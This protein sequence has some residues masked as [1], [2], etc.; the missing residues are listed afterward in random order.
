MSARQ[1]AHPED[2]MNTRPMSS[3]ELAY[4][5]RAWADGDAARSAA[6][7]LLIRHGVWLTRADFILA[8]VSVV[9][10]APESEPFATIDWE[11]AYATASRLPCSPSEEAALR[12]ACSL[13]SRNCPVVLGEAVVRLDSHN[14]ALVSAAILRAGGD[15]TIYWP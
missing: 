2:L 3:S 9:S 5:L 13:A 12:I 8:A 6:V 11:T 10:D 7:E 1:H 15:R 14:R 4:G